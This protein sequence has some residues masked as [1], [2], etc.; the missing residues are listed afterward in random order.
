MSADVY[1][2]F[3]YHR[4]KTAKSY[5][6][7]ELILHNGIIGG[8]E[9]Q[10]VAIVA[11][12]IVAVGGDD[13]VLNCV[14]PETRVVN[15][16][17]R[18]VL[19]G[20]IDS[21]IHFHE[22]ALKRQDLQLSTMTSHNEMLDLLAREAASRPP[23][24]WILGQGWNEAEWP[25]KRMVTRC[26][27]DRV[28][29]DHPV[30][31]WRCD[32]HL[33]VANSAALAQAG[34]VRATPNPPQGEIAKDKAGEPTGILRESAI[35]LLREVIQPPPADHIV[36]A[37][38]EAMKELYRYGI[39]GICDL[40]LMHDNDGGAAL[41]TFYE[42]ER[43]GELGLRTWVTL[44]GGQ[45]DQIISLGLRT[46]FGS[47]RLRLGHVKFFADGGVGARTAWMHEPYLDAECSMACMDMETLSHKIQEADHAGLAVAVHAI[48]DR[49]NHELISIFAGLQHRRQP[50]SL[51]PAYPHRLEHLQIIQPVDVERLRS[52][53]LALG[54]SPANLPLDI[55][56]IDTAL[57]TRGGWAYPFRTLLD[58][59][60]PVMFSSDCPVCNPDP[61]LGIHAAVTRQRPDGTPAGG[62]FPESRV[63]VGEA[64]AAYTTVPAM[65]HGAY[66]LGRI[67]ASYHADLV[68]FSRDVLSCP[69]DEI[70]DAGVAMTV[71]AGEIVF[72]DF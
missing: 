43:T 7:P 62:W 4:M 13:S 28:V 23:G 3:E 20:C 26:D 24:Q 15:L 72:Q 2:F 54:V 38:Q 17:G 67:G 50:G 53:P 16:E 8:K 57:G 63:T 48:G 59:G 19:P 25:E 47:D 33:A 29:P 37:Y 65:V 46:G 6:K 44:S 32:L 40:R 52:L 30:L 60:L 36:T 56:L 39:T 22:W 27:L 66:D 51:A 64:V 42:L 41:R 5:L 49:A 21:H 1:H 69:P 58:T 11:G 35:N 31:L 14:R 55:N 9:R 12:R 61:L 10:G 45:L 18:R 68:V 34:I 70:V 71:F